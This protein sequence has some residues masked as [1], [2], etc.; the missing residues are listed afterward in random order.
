MIISE[1]QILQLIEVARDACFHR[2]YHHTE[3]QKEIFELLDEISIQQSEE[4]K[5]I[6]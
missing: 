1:K 3:Y 6:E 5:V 2:C 4:L